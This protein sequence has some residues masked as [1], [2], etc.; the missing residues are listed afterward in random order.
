MSVRAELVGKVDAV[1]PLP[2]RS[3]WHAADRGCAL[4]WRDWPA[5]RNFAPATPLARGSPSTTNR[6]SISEQLLEQRRELRLKQL[7]RRP[8]RRR[9]TGDVDNPIDRFIVAGWKDAPAGPKPQPCDDA[10]FLRRVYLDLIG[11]IPTGRKSTASLS[12]AKHGQA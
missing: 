2:F 9:S 4:R 1:D 8:R 5:C 7:P 6:P 12:A 11:V 10:T 3:L